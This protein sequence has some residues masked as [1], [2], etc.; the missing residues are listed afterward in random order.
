M[1]SLKF[2]KSVGFFDR[3]ISKILIKR[4]KSWWFTSLTCLSLLITKYYLKGLLPHI[5][6]LSQYLFTNLSIYWPFQNSLITKRRLTF[7][8][9]L[10]PITWKIPLYRL[11]SAQVGTTGT[12]TNVELFVK[13]WHTV[14]LTQSQTSP[15]LYRTNIYVGLHH[16]WNSPSQHAQCQLISN[17]SLQLR[18][19]AC[20]TQTIV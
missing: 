14:G 9:R 20:G 2:S 17:N 18:R 6:A 10:S 3:K 1:N 5:S 12:H 16:S 15:S 13:T 8:V 11:T 19:T 7:H 4:N